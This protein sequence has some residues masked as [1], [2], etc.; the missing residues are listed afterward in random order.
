[1][2]ESLIDQLDKSRYRLLLWFTTA[3]T[4]WFGAFIVKDWIGR[5]LVVSLVELT[6][7]VFFLI[8]GVRYFRLGR[9]VNSDIRLK[10]A[11]NNEMH[12]L[13]AYKSFLCGFVV[14]MLSVTILLIGSVFYPMSAVV[15]CEIILFV[16]V[17]SS[18]I[19][20]LI[21]NRG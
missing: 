10:E 8:Y 3:W 2:D 5:S 12:K 6:G 1:M 19:A 7:S 16:G 14:S 15:V 4:V 20:A 18:L 9:R 21:Y 17:L 13:Y 11:L